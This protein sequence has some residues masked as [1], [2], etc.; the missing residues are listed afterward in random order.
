MPMTAGKAKRSPLARGLILATASALVLALALGAFWLDGRLSLRLPAALR[1]PGLA[2]LACGLALIAWAEV[3]LLRVV[4]STGAFGDP[5]GTLVAQGPYRHV[6]NPIYIG[7]FGVLLGLSWWR[8]SPT[9]LV[10][11]LGFLPV[12]HLF[13][14]RSEEPA[15]RRRLGAQYDDHLRRVPRWLPRL[16]RRV[17]GV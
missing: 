12:M 4:R 17:G 8:S 9:L 11:A 2:A 15:T 1:W 13:V 14:T 3:T 5:P 10:L 7:A 6:R 16:N